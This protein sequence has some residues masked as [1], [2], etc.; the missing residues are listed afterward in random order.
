MICILLLRAGKL[1]EAMKEYQKAVELNLIKIT[2]CFIVTSEIFW[3]HLVIIMRHLFSIIKP[4][5]FNLKMLLYTLISA[6]ILL[7]QAKTDDALNHF[8]KAIKLQPEFADANYK[9][10]LILEQKGLIEEAN[11]HYLEAIRIN[12]LYKNIKKE[13][14]NNENE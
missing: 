9:L 8:R 1:Q 11:R 7:R 4:Y 6:I 3:L 10:A 12:H 2:W 5:L 14:A 13:N